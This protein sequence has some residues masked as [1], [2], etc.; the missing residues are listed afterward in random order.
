MNVDSLDKDIHR[1]NLTLICFGFIVFCFGQ[2]HLKENTLTLNILAIEFENTFALAI[3]AWVSLFWFLW[4]YYQ[5][6][7]IPFKKKFAGK[8]IAQ[9]KREKYRK[10]VCSRLPI[11][12]HLVSSAYLIDNLIVEKES[13]NGFCLAI[14]IRGAIDKELLEKI[15][16]PITGMYP[17][18]NQI[19]A[20]VMKNEWVYIPL[21]HDRDLKRLAL[22]PLIVRIIFHE[23]TFSSF[24]IPYLFAVSSILVGLARIKGIL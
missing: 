1:R 9:S 21:S 23:A 13:V 20:P 2:G 15:V 19:D 16:S 8:M 7:R 10:F 22:D 17:W 6:T 14:W 11:P 24:V 4:R 5:E 3:I 12:L 18:S